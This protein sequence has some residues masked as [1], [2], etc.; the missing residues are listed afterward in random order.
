MQNDSGMNLLQSELERLEDSLVSSTNQNRTYMWFYFTFL[1]YFTY[2]IGTIDNTILLKDNIKVIIPVLGFNIDLEMFLS[3]LPLVILILHYVFLYN[4]SHHSKRLK[5]WLTSSGKRTSYNLFNKLPI[6]VF[7]EVI[8]DEKEQ[9]KLYVVIN[10]FYFFMPFFL[11]IYAFSFSVRFDYLIINILYCICTVALL[12]INFLVAIKTSKMFSVKKTKYIVIGYS[13]LILELAF[14]LYFL[15]KNLY[16]LRIQ[17]EDYS[18]KVDNKFLIENATEYI[19]KDL[20][21]VIYSTGYTIK[22]KILKHSYFEKSSFIGFDFLN[23]DFSDTLFSEVVF[24]KSE[25][26]NIK[27]TSTLFSNSDFKNSIF[28]SSIDSYNENKFFSTQFNIRE[29]DFTQSNFYNSNL[30]GVIFDDVKFNKTKFD[31]SNLDGARIDYRGI[32][33]DNNNLITFTDKSSMKSAH[34]LIATAN[35]NRINFEE[36]NLDGTYFYYYEKD[37]M[38]NK[39]FNKIKSNSKGLLF[40]DSIGNQEKE[41]DFFDVRKSQICSNYY[42]VKPLLNFQIE[43]GAGRDIVKKFNSKYKDEMLEYVNKNCYYYLKHI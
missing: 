13:V 27:F 4:L 42:L 10:F 8:F 34:L 25:F 36:I 35:F 18:K 40:L 22:N 5:V 1:I 2:V 16:S 29:L 39:S 30:T 38:D 26:R 33:S 19:E 20:L 37:Y 43:F 21:S 31:S 32:S 7:N 17:G 23:I 3:I 11:I 24:D 6:F 41:K 9:S 15:S 28:K 14:L 12:I